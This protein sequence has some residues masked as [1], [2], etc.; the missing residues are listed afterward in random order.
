MLLLQQMIVL[1]IYIAL[2]YGAAK[3][4]VMDETHEADIVKCTHQPINALL[5]FPD[6]KYEWYCKR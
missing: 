3:K 2:G 1:F 4:G 6:T 5:F